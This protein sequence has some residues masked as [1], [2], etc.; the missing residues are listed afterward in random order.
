[1][2]AAVWSLHLVAHLDMNVPREAVTSCGGNALPTNCPYLF[3]FEQSPTEFISVR[4][5][6][7]SQFTLIH[8]LS[9]TPLCRIWNEFL[10]VCIRTCYTWLR[11]IGQALVASSPTRMILSFCHIAKEYRAPSLN[12]YFR[13]V[14]PT[15][16][17]LLAEGPVVISGILDR[18]PW[19]MS[20]LSLQ[21]EGRGAFQ[22]PQVA[23]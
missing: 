3:S 12:V 8:F 19:C 5:L 1:M 10:Q 18:S 14:S 2:Q 22:E 15:S 16:S 6:L 4:Y 13:H 7:I 21:R 17:L 20:F 9:R 23:L 11:P